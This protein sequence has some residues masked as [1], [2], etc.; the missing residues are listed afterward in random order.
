MSYAKRAKERPKRT[1]KYELAE[2]A[3]KIAWLV[4]DRDMIETALEFYFYH[5]K[6]KTELQ[7]WIENKK[8]I[9]NESK[10]RFDS[11]KR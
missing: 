11:A 10:V 4:K 6:K 5:G 2:T 3:R 1:D 9:L 7:E 8:V